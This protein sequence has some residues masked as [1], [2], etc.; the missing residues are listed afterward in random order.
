MEEH[1][2]PGG[3]KLPIGD[4]I[5]TTIKSASPE[6]YGLILPSPNSPLFREY[7]KKA[8]DYAGLSTG[9]DRVAQLS[10]FVHDSIMYDENFGKGMKDVPLYKALREGRGVCKEKATVLYMILT[11]EG[12]DAEYVKG[13]LTDKNG[14]GGHAW[15]KVR[16]GND[17]YL[18]DPT[19]EKLFEYKLAQEKGYEETSVIFTLR[20]IKRV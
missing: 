19:N 12:F 20:R 7:Y 5:Y 4:N 18:V 6:G 1:V 2:I 3:A 16:I 10:K 9:L 8:T 13:T 14:T 11:M 17:V 15:V